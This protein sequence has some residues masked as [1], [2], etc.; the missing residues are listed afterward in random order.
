[1]NNQLNMLDATFLYVETRRSP[2]HIAGLQIL[3]IPR[4]K[5]RVFFEELKR[6]IAAR[7]PSVAFMTRRLVTSPL[8]PIQSTTRTRALRIGD[9]IGDG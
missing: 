2:M 6:H 7:A 1:M 4:D 8:R 5:R 3:D 9:R